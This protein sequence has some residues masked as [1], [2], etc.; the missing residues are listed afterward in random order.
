MLFYVASVQAW[1]DYILVQNF[2]GGAQASIDGVWAFYKTVMPWLVAQD[3]VHAIFPFGELQ[4]ILISLPWAYP[5]LFRLL[6]GYG[7]RQHAQPVDEGRS[8]Y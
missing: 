1:S 6:G 7:Q 8:A 4:L 3:Y 5:D 2:G